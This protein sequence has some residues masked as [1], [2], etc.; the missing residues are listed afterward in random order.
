MSAMSC[1]F[2]TSHPEMF[3][4]NPAFHLNALLRLVSSLMSHPLASSHGA[5]QPSA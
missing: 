3:P 5:A 2:D 4:L 1:T